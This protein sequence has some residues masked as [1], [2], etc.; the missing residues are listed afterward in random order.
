MVLDATTNGLVGSIVASEITLDGNETIGP[1]AANTG[2]GIWTSGAPISLLDI[3]TMNNVSD[4]GAGTS[5][6]SAGGGVVTLERVEYRAN[7]GVH[8][9]ATD[10]Y[11]A[12][13]TMLDCIIEWNVGGITGGV[14]YGARLVDQP[15]AELT[16]TTSDLGVG[17]DDNAPFDVLVNSGM[18]NTYSYGNGV[19]FFCDLAAGTCI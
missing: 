19:S 18:L 15:F 7:Q 16:V 11:D 5:L 12:T 9:G 8:A 6:N 17:V 14:Q 4:Y 10:I 13:V 3:L 2:G 1:A